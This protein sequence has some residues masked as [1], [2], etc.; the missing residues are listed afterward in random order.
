MRSIK[1]YIDYKD[2]YILL[3]PYYLFLVGDLLRRAA[4]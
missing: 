2:N 1:R 3:R 4:H